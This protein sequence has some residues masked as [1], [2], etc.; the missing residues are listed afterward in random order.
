MAQVV[1]SVL[2]RR[3]DVVMGFLHFNAFLILS[4]HD[5]MQ[6]RPFASM[7][8]TAYKRILLPHNLALMTDRVY[9]V[10]SR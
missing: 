8:L 7:I 3:R 4:G 2:Q 10:S 9:L 6:A 1:R 5:S